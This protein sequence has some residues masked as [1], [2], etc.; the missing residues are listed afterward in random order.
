MKA[1]QIDSA[2][3]EMKRFIA[4]GGKS[5]EYSRLIKEFRQI[6]DEEDAKQNAE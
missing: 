5:K 4:I 6:M 2:L 3:D 1:G